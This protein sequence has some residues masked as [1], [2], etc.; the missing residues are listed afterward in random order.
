M[1]YDV[2]SHSYHEIISLQKK[3]R[4]SYFWL[5]PNNIFN[6]NFSLLRIDEKSK[7]ITSHKNLTSST[8]SLFNYI[9]ESK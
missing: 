6:G 5:Q 1:L 2:Y 4:N 8:F 9:L 3:H 7:L